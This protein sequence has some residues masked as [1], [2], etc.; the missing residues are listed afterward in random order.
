MTVPTFVT[1]KG[2]TPRADV[3]TLIQQQIASLASH[4]DRIVDCRVRVEVPHRHHTAANAVHA[5]IELTVP[6]DRLVVEHI[7][8]LYRDPS[9]GGDSPLCT[10]VREAFVVMQRR[11][12]DYADRQRNEVRPSRTATPV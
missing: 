7:A 12:A 9:G 11:L 6:R 2:L 5:L 4:Y 3:E 1:F 8:E 10:A